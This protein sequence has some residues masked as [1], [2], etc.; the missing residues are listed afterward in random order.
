MGASASTAAAIVLRIATSASTQ[1]FVDRA[2]MQYRI[3][4]PELRV[5]PAAS[6][7][8]TGAWTKLANGEVDAAFIN[9]HPAA[10]LKQ[11]APDIALMPMWGVAFGPAANVPA[12]GGV[13][14]LLSREVLARIYCGNITRWNHPLLAALN[15][16]ISMPAEPIH[17]ALP[18]EP[19]ESTRE[20]THISRKVWAQFRDLVPE[21]DLPDWPLDRFASY[22][23]VSHATGPLSLVIG[24][25]HAIASVIG[26]PK[27][28]KRE[29]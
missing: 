18:L 27:P 15:P 1:S 6:P 28:S 9:F 8:A 29:G 14:L 19:L 20:F 23:F 22:S 25:P 4:R 16:L 21:S 24:T 5:L 3:M 11:A 13:P 12:A 10:A 2:A 17:I 7:T 26:I